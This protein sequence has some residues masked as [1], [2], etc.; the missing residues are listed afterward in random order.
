MAA[1][2]YALMVAL[3][4]LSTFAFLRREKVRADN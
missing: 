4:L 2:A 1:Y 3:V